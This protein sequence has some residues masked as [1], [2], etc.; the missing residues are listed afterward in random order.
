M[1]TIGANRAAPASP[2]GGRVCAVVVTYRPG[3]EVPAHIEAIRRQVGA[4][5]VV[6]NEATAASRARLATIVGQPEVHLIANPENLG[7]ATAFNQGAAFA[8][9]GGFEWLATFDQDSAAPEGYIAALLA[10]HEP[11]PG[12]DHTAVLAPLYRDRHLGFVYSPA[13][14]PVRDD[15][16]GTVPVSVTASSG[17][18]VATAALRAVGGFRDDFFMACVDLEFCLRCRRAGWN[19][20]EVRSVVL[21]HAMGR[22]EQRRWLWLNPR[23]NDYDASRRYYQ[24]RNLLVLYATHGRADFRWAMR[25][26]WHYASDLLKLLFFCEH[27]G[28]KV[29]AVA[30]GFWH[31]LTGRRGRW[32]AAVAAP[33]RHDAR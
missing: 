22:Y 10:A 15:S 33:A 12:A 32:P 29:R 11:Y 16:I 26:A 18:L 6:D 19:V 21:D 7:I 20:L 31:A 5:V 27:R 1:T 13:T 2:A 8:V 4:V 25:D 30:T 3:P 17:N 23:I 28:E 24:A 9:A 14:G